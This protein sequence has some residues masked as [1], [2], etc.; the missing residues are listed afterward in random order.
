MRK[1]LVIALAC[2]C[3]S[4]YAQWF[5]NSGTFSVPDGDPAGT[6]VSVVVSGVGNVLTDVNFGTVIE[7]TWQGDFIMRLTAPGGASVV[8]MTRPGSGTGSTFGYSAN[9]YGDPANPQNMATWF[10]L[11]DS[12]GL[13]YAAPDGTPP[14]TIGRPG[15]PNVD[16]S[17]KPYNDLNAVF[18]GIDPNGTWVVNYSDNAFADTGSVLMTGVQI[19]AVP[20]PASMIALGLG[21]TALLAR[22]RRKRA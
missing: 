6:D 16:G 18:A 1:I 19:S 10:V 9:N 22:R 11:D 13:L 5:T 12:A 8:M 3:G 14:G 7:H 4:A 20:E 21:V 17:W 15:I 2:I